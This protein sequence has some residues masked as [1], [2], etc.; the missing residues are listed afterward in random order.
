[1][2]SLKKPKTGDESE[3]EEKYL[4][5]D[6]KMEIPLPEGC[7]KVNLGIPILVIVNKVDL[8]LHGDKKSY[9]EE[10]FDFIQKH[11]REYSLQY[12]ASVVFTSAN[13]DRN[14]NVTY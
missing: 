1:M 10:N 14:L 2:E 8:L 12:G 7:L 3:E 6:L 13:A 9:L 4:E 5:S 11:I